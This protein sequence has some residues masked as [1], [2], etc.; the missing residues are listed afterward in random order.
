MNQQPIG[1]FDSGIGGLSVWSEVVKLLPNEQTIYLADSSHAPYGE[2]SKDEILAR[3]IANTEFLIK[4][5][6]KLIV[7]ACNTATTNSIDYLRSHYPVKFVG[8]EPAIKPAAFSSESKV[9]G[10]LATEATLNSELYKHTLS[11]YEKDV[12]VV[13]KQGTGLVSLIEQGKGNSE[14]TML[15]LTRFLTPMLDAGID[16][17][18]L[19]CTHYP[20]LIPVIKKIIGSNIE[21]VSGEAAI[22]RRTKKILTEDKLLVENFLKGQKHLLL[23]N[24]NAGKTTLERTV[25]KLNCSSSTI[26]IAA[27]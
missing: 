13:Q 14:E 21:I 24:A 26:K 4:Q 22:A 11:K 16:Q 8:T 27:W 9:I 1:F 19:G 12:T 23:T 7:V 2:K 18:V 20:F 5:H 15:L 17:L 10:I 6:C 3:C 25:N